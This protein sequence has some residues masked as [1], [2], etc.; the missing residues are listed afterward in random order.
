M[1]NT[2][3]PLNLAKELLDRLDRYEVKLNAMAKQIDAMYND[4]Y[5]ET[6]TS[7]N[8]QDIPDEELTMEERI[9]KYGQ[10]VAYTLMSD[11][12]EVMKF[13]DFLY[14]AKKKGGQLSQIERD[15]LDIA[16]KDFDDIRIS[17]KHLAVLKSIH[18][19]LSGIMT[20]PFK[21][22]QGYMYKLEGYQPEWE[23]FQ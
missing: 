5:E 3:I 7:S 2:Y 22:T 15:L 17:V 8:V 10:K 9:K 13:K 4:D 21:Y 6:P 19:K 12:V 20:W 11:P 18:R 16:D 14:E 23:F 1:N